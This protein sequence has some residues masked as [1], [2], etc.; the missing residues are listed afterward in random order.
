MNFNFKQ[1]F[2][3][4][5]VSIPLIALLSLSLPFYLWDI[6]LLVSGW[7]Y[8]A[9]ALNPWPLLEKWPWYLL[10]SFGTW[11]ALALAVLALLLVVAGIFYRQLHRYRR[12][13]LYL[14]AV[15]II[16]PGLIVN[17]IFK[18][19][20]GR[21]RPRDI[22]EFGGQQQYHVLLQPDWG[23]KGRSFPCG[24]CSCAFYFFVLYFLL[25][26]SKR[27]WLSFAGLAFGVSYG[28]LMGIARIGQGG[29]YVSDVMWSA[30]FVYLTAAGLYHIMYVK[31][32]TELSLSPQS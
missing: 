27:R 22:I 21:P 16:G 25:K 3:S 28:L 31:E 20:F 10:Y 6:D 24:H 12:H 15:M 8:N 14:V 18:D 9:S 11:P 1:L 26:R 2:F 17:V 13:A 30:G 29:H 5:D 4:R 23:N 32:E 7:F 19:N